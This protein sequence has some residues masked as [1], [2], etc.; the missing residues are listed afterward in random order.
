MTGL[1]KAAFLRTPGRGAPV[2]LVALLG[3]LALGFFSQDVIA[4]WLVAASAFLPVLVWLGAGAPGLPVLPAIAALYYVYYALPILRGQIVTYNADEL[5]WAAVNVATFLA[6]ASIACWPFL[7]DARRRSQR[8]GRDV[9]TDQQA[10]RLVFVGL[11]FGII[12]HL[13]FI[14]GS[15]SLLG[16][17]LGLVRAVVLTLTS[18]SCYLL[19]WARA[20]R[21][22]VGGSWAVALMG[23]CL[24]MLLASSGLLLVGGVMNGLAALFGYVI[25]A[26]RIPWI[27]L[28]IA[29]ALLSVLHAG[30]LEIRKKYWM[31][32]SQ[33]LQESSVVQVPGLMTDWL[34]AGTVALTTGSAESDVLERASLLHMLL[35]VQRATPTYVPY[36][37]GGTYALLPSML[38]PRF[39]EPDKTVGAAGLNLLS[40]RYGLQVAE[41]TANT[42]IGW[43]LIAEGYANFGYVAVL[44]VGALLG[45]LCGILMRL[46]VR[47]RP[48][49]LA[50]FIT[51][52]GAIVLFDLDADL[53]YLLT[54]LAQS[55]G[56]VLVIAL[57]ARLLKGR[58]PILPGAL[59]AHIDAGTA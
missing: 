22:L 19:G 49:S 47:A 59:S 20:S 24:L 50:M 57:F 37:E 55:V 8:F 7:V 34:V 1:A 30:K 28:G 51:I 31:P 40:I 39:I 56:A 27:G 41:S 13:A 17:A 6:A 21:L 23:L 14:S 15:L 48:V 54:T 35:L 16:T 36:L 12:Y 10:V 52:A 42:T 45:A 5:I 46:S 2:A 4:Y 58:A 11:A 38:T 18:I 33:S 29:F 32:Q 44:L 25:T 26:R 53:A 9:V 3:T 43:G